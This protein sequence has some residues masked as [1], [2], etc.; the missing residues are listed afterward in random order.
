[1]G[2]RAPHR[3]RLNGHHVGTLGP[4]EH[5]GAGQGLTLPEPVWSTIG[6]ANELVVEPAAAE[7]RCLGGFVLEVAL[8]DGRTTR[9]RVDPA[10]HATTGTWDG[11]RWC[12]PALHRVDPLAALRVPLD[13]A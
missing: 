2:S 12:T 3:V 6:A 7:E 8:A 11:W 4:L 9:S 13:F 1:M 10:L 5:F